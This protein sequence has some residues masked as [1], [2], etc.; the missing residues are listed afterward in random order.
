M[1]RPR[2]R[3]AI[4]A[5]LIALTAP[6]RLSA[7]AAAGRGPGRA[8]AAGVGPGGGLS[9][10]ATLPA[11][12]AQPNPLD[13]ISPVTNAMLQNLSAADWLT[14]APDVGRPGL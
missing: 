5:L 9:P 4:C 12:P 13:R 8:G 1:N 3:M 7:Q 6:L 10:Y 14:L 11:W 2:H